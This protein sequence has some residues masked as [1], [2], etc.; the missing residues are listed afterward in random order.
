MPVYQC[1]I[2]LARLEIKEK[3]RNI[4]FDRRFTPYGGPYPHRNTLECP[5][6]KGLSEEELARLD[7]VRIL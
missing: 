2:C 1:K 7:S 4:T 6:M 5:L 3:E